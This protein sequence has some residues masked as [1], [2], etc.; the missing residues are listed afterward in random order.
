MVKVC[1][2]CSKKFEEREETMTPAEELGH[3]FLEGTNDGY[4]DQLCPDCKE[5]LGLLNL[6]AFSE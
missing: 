3:I 4:A 2:R 1:Q 5:E 6:L